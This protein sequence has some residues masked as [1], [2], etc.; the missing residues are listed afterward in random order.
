[1]S[2]SAARKLP[3]KYKYSRVHELIKTGEAMRLDTRA[4]GN[5]LSSFQT[6]SRVVVSTTKE[7]LPHAC[8]HE[9]R[10]IIIMARER[11]SEAHRAAPFVIGTAARLPRS[12]LAIYCRCV[13]HFTAKRYS[14]VEL[15]H[16]ARDSFDNCRTL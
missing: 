9:K 12:S 16:G 6:V 5:F 7:S 2:C 4:S 15:C 1:M 13:L 11:E 10:G 3:G 14:V 8:V